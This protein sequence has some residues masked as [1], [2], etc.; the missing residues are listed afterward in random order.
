ME[1]GSESLR[2]DKWMWAA[3]LVKTRGDAVDAIN[4]GRVEVN[5]RRVKPS[6]ELNPGD[7]LELTTGPVRREV[8]VR[9]I[10]RRRGPASEAVLLYEET[11]ESRAARER[12]AEER[13]L[14]R[15]LFDDAGSRP[16]KRDRRRYD[17][18]RGKPG[19]SR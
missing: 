9:G 16:T 7:R 6:R 2:V 12:H 14:T 11:P 1:T 5:G 17:A 18:E 8:T 4:G 19:P 10:S 3:R 15:P 13:R